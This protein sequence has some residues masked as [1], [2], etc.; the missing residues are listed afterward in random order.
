MKTTEPAPDE[1]DHLDRTFAIRLHDGYLYAPQRP[2]F[3]LQ[4]GPADRQGEW[5]VVRADHP[6]EARVHVR[7]RVTTQH[8]QEAGP[9]E[10][11]AADLLVAGSHKDV[12][13]TLEACSSQAVDQL[14]P[15]VA[16]PS[17]AEIRVRVL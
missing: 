12:Y 7:N 14:P 3:A 11:C 1:R 8:C 6:S 2:E 5:F 17:F 10:N 13:G 4:A 16:T 15:S 9:C